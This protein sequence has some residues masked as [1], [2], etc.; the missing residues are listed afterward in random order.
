M[1][2]FGGGFGDAGMED[3]G[4]LNGETFETGME[5]A[6][7]AD[8]GSL[9]ESISGRKKTVAQKKR[10]KIKSFTRQYFD[11][12]GESGEPGYAQKAMAVDFTNNAVHM[13]D[14]LKE[15]VG[16]I[17]KMVDS[18]EIEKEVIIDEALENA[19]RVGETI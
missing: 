14:Q 12:L 8:S 4:D 16:R 19:K 11:M 17:D 9:M 1:D 10:D 2:D 5:N 7:E 18:G 6:P 3:A 15:M 13:K